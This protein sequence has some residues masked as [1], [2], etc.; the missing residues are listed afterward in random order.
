[1]LQPANSQNP[2]FLCACC[3]CCCGVLRH[4]KNEANPG[5]LVANPFVAYHEA[6]SC[7]V[8]GSCV[9]VCPMAALTLDAN[10]AIHFEQIRCIGCGLCISVCPNGAMQLVRKP[11]AEQPKTPKNTLSTY[12]GVARTRGAGNFFG[13]AWTLIKA[14]ISRIRVSR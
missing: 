8:C 9:E 12:V 6:A 2:I 3:S 13:I 7:I 11:S 10:D 1:V 4:I 14:Y 5:S